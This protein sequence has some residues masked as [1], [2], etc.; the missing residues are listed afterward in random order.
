[1][2]EKRL[3]VNADDFGLSQGINRG[4]IQCFQKGIVTS[5]TIIP[6]G[7]AF[8]HAVE[9]AKLNPGLGVGVHL[10][11]IAEEPALPPD[12]VKSLIDSDG[13]FHESHMRFIL[14]YFFGKIDLHEIAGELEAQLVKVSDAGLLITHIDSHRH[15]HMLPDMLEIVTGL[16][17]KFNI[18]A[19]RI[20]DGD[21][22][23]LFDPKEFGL[24]L[25]RRRSKK[26]LSSSGLH[27]TE[28]FWGLTEGG[29]ITEQDILLLLDHLQPGVTEIMCHPGYLDEVYLERYAN[30][31]YE[32][33]VEL[34]AL[35]SAK[36]K[37]KMEDNKICLVN[38]KDLF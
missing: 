34:A 10:T 29:R 37:D 18:Q 16:A 30:W 24:H 26:Q 15:L 8:D 17:K 13:N 35:T 1:M 36:V 3:I 7:V 31:G 25:L 14:R 11:L 23:R 28:Y 33:E 4:I 27:Y 22:R 9:L 12:K 20:P 6:T 38:F 2:N 32:P 19:I 5:A 21:I